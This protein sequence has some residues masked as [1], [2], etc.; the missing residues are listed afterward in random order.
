M[1]ATQAWYQ[2]LE[3]LLKG[4]PS[5][6]MMFLE[7]E[8]TLWLA[9]KSS[10]GKRDN[11]VSSCSSSKPLDTVPYLLVA[12]PPTKLRPILLD[13]TE[14]WS[15]PH[16]PPVTVEYLVISANS[17]SI[18]AFWYLM[19]WNAYSVALPS[20][21]TLWCQIVHMG[22]IKTSWVIFVKPQPE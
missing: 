13:C 8:I 4:K 19:Q 7:G 16:Q 6:A 18:S 5:L 1:F 11:P 12:Q 9:V 17:Y 2:A 10:A 20:H 15:L 21:L 22:R 3:C 14:L